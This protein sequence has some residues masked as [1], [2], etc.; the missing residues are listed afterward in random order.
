MV[1][2]QLILS[3]SWH[4]TYIDLLGKL[5]VIRR[6]KIRNYSNYLKRDFLYLTL[7]FLVY[8]DLCSQILLF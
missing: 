6:S 3:F 1:V 4:N 7:Y 8:A 2:K 5:R